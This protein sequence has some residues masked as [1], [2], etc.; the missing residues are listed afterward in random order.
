MVCKEWIMGE[1][2]IRNSGQKVR[3]RV[4]MQS[5]DGF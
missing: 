1:R 4:H 3:S 2:K 5:N